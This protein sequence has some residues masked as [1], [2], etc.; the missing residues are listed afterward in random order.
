[1]QIKGVN[2]H[3][4]SLGIGS[5]LGLAAGAAGS[6][7]LYRLVLLPKLQREQDAK[8]DDRVNAESAALRSHFD[9]KLNDRL[10]E[11]L[12]PVVS[13]DEGTD[14]STREEPTAVGIGRRPDRPQKINYAAAGTSSRQQSPGDVDEEGVDP[15]VDDDSSDSAGDPDGDRA[16]TRNV[17]EQYPEGDRP[18][19]RR[20][21]RDEY[22]EV[23]PGYVTEQMT[24]YAAD[25][26]LCDENDEP[27]RVPAE[28]IGVEKPLFGYLRE[29]PYS[30]LVVNEA[31]H[32][33]IEVVYH[34]GSYVDAVLGYKGPV[35]KQKEG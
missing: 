15:D 2:I 10:K 8:V 13:G 30:Y 20:V 7:G 19:I 22:G 14:G 29:E 31:L 24:W 16:E 26:I 32:V 27:I 28:V 11:A 34:G 12:A 3:G 35:E 17:F 6:F 5:V 18:K 25:G 9:S 33:C 1:M 21:D 23:P 4:P